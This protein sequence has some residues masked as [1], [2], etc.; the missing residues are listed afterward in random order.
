MPAGTV[1][2]QAEV[3]GRHL[4]IF[5]DPVGSGQ[6]QQAF[7][8]ILDVMR[9]PVGRP[10]AIVMATVPFG[11]ACAVF[12]MLVTGVTMNVYSQIG[13]VL[14]VGIMAKN[15]ILI[16]E[17]ANQL[18]VEKGESAAEAAFEAAT[19]RFRPIL[20]TSISTVLGAVP[21]AFATGAGAETRNPMGIVVVGG[22]MLSTIITLYVIPI[23][24]IIMD[25]LCV[26]FTGKS[27]AYGLIKAAEIERETA[28]GASEPAHAK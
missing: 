6:F 13:L 3:M 25:K 17:F 21:I 9:A 20:M 1:L 10:T 15:G 23:V 28:G 14:V 8:E 27:S 2:A 7:S 11:L 12:A 4:R 16:V 18:Q 5:D 24:Y 19:L 26:K 22:L